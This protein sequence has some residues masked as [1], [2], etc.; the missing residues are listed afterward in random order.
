MDFTAP[1][2]MEVPMPLAVPVSA[3]RTDSRIDAR[4]RETRLLL[5]RYHT[6]GDREAR[7]ELIQRFLPLARQLARRYHRGREPLED[8][9]QVASLGLIKAVDR[10]EVERTTSFT[11]YA[12]PVMLGELRRHFRDTGWGVHVPRALQELTM[13]LDQTSERL[14]AELGRS[15]TP[16]ELAAA[17]NRSL[18]EVLEGLSAG[19]AA[20][21]LSLDMRLGDDTDGGETRLSLMGD[22]DLGYDLVDERSVLAQTLGALSPRDRAVLSMRFLEDLTQA[23]IAERLSLSQM[24]ISRILRR[25]L[26]RLQIVAGGT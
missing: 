14:R 17:S 5:S 7:A 12:V 26:G 8:L 13:R 18:S 16:A 19:H 2:P 10:F 23:E 9:V 22:D 24:S 25:V 1:P 3:D 11:S 15:P 21:P 4:G 6:F 20:S